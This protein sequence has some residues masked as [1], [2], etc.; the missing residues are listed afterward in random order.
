MLVIDPMF[1]VFPDPGLS[2][3]NCHFSQ[4]KNSK[5]L[6]TDTIESSLSTAIVLYLM[7]SPLCLSG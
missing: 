4:K 6:I 2:L 7:L 1:A 5:S 3:A